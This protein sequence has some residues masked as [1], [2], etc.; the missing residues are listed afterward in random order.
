MPARYHDTASL[1]GRA[2]HGFRPG[3]PLS[4]EPLCPRALATK[5]M[6]SERF[7]IVLVIIACHFLERF[8]NLRMKATLRVV[9]QGPI[10]DL[11]GQG[12][13]ERIFQ[14]G[15]ESLFRRGIPPSGDAR[16]SGAVLRPQAR[17]R[18]AAAERER[19]RR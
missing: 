4:T 9:K 19:S 11:I 16:G 13:F 17:P 7:D 6:V 8:D 15:K 14:L 1:Q 5:G 12:V 18:H 2:R 3:L 10:G